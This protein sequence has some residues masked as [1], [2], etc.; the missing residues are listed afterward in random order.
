MATT[1]QV[2]AN[3]RNA[4]RST[5][6]KTDEWKG[7]VRRNAL[8]HGMTARTVMPDLP[9]EF[10]KR[11]QRTREWA[12][13]VPPRNA[14]E[15]DLLD[16]AA[17]LMDA[18]ERGERIETQMLGALQ[19]TQI[20][21]L[22]RKLLYIAGPEEVKVI[23]MPHWAEDPGLL[24]SQLEESTEGCRWLLERWE[25]Y[26]NLLGRRTKW[27]EPELLRFI[28]LQGK[29]V[30][31]SIY[32]PALNSIFLAWD[33][34]VPKYAKLEWH[35]FQEVKPRTDPAFNHRLVWREIA[36]RP[37]DPDAAWAVLYGVVNQHVGRL[38]ELL[39]R[40]EASA[41]AEDTDWAARA[42]LDGSPAFERHRRCQ[43]ARHRELLRTLEALRKMRN[44][45]FGMRNGKVGMPDDE[46]QMANDGCQIPANFPRG[47]RPVRRARPMAN[48]LGRVASSQRPVQTRQRATSRGGDS[49]TPPFG[50]AWFSR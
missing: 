3:R 21:E 34:L 10:P 40:N 30:V 28:R 22:G 29:N 33:V 31:E 12:S 17:G 6:P 39:A 41:S 11:R 26:R 44:A 47:R 23:R 7:R 43:S 8:K 46:C 2:E 49:P 37:V 48:R 32:D 20:R 42:G 18:L 5:L 9:L 13:D 27:E 1:A 14:I 16:Q 24:V 45:D 36:E 4:Q 19:H 15:R 35:Y 25:E 50:R 38:Q